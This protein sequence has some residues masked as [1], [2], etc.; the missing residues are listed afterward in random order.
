MLPCVDAFIAAANRY[1]ALVERPAQDRVQL[2][3]T[4]HEALAHCYSEAL[5]L[6]LPRT[7]DPTLPEARIPLEAWRDVNGRI[8]DRLGSA[9][10]YWVILDPADGG[11]A[12]QASLADDLADIWRDLKEGLALH[13]EGLTGEALWH[14]RFGFDSHWGVHAAEALRVI[15]LTVL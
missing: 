3:T 7:D 15:R 13:A 11:T 14:W 2:L 10:G 8:L 9:D 6:A 12:V 5:R 4:V 1:C